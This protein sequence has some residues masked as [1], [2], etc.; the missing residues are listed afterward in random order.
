M[1]NEYTKL[2][3]LNHDAVKFKIEQ[4]PNKTNYSFFKYNCNN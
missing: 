2:V 1:T 3:K 4:W